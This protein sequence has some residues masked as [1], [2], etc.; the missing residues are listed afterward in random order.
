MKELI[1]NNTLEADFRSRRDIDAIY[2]ISAAK[3][4]VLLK[5]FLDVNFSVF[6]DPVALYT[7]SRSRL[8]GNSTQSAQELNNLMISDIPWLMGTN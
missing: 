6:A 4:L 1:G 7:T 2:M 8:S 5:P 3:D